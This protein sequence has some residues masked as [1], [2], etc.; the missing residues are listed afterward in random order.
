LTYHHKRHKNTKK[1]KGKQMTRTPKN[2]V[3]VPDDPDPSPI[4]TSDSSAEVQSANRQERK[5]A[6]SSYGRKQ[7]IIAGNT[8]G[9]TAADN[10]GKKTILG[11]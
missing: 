11:G 5:K 10:A 6:A 2:N 9:N 7:S 3:T 4:I 1:Q 8:A